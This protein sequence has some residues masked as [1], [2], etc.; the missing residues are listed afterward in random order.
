MRNPKSTR[1]WQHVLEAIW[2]YLLLASKINNKLHGEVFNFGPINNNNYSVLHVVKTM[3]KS[4]EKV[5]WKI[6]NSKNKS[7]YESNLLKINS[8]KAKQIIKWKCIL[9]FKETILMVVNWYK[10]N[11]SNSKIIYKTTI[12]QIRNYEELIRIRKMK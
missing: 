1:P 11:D 9:T 7:F 12:N 6:L 3:K 2:G 4:W 10:K 8:H 5:S